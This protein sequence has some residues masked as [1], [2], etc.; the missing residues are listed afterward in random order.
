MKHLKL[1]GLPALL[2]ASMALA[3]ASA[4][5]TGLTGAGGAALGA[6]TTISLE[7]QTSLAMH[8]PFG[9]IE[10]R[11]SNWSGKT[12]TSG[13]AAETVKV[14]METVDFSECNS[15]MTTLANGILEFHTQG[16]TANNNATLTSSGFELTTEYFGTHCIFKTSNTDIGVVTGSANTGGNA[17]LDIS[18][19]IPRTGGRSGAFCGSTAQW[20]GNYKVTSPSTLNVD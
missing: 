18:A 17:V 10:C 15:T 8:P 3:A 7:A 9:T 4:S 13:G 19:T 12:S 20:T 16:S 2:A 14:S 1:L 6:G 5:A 11:N